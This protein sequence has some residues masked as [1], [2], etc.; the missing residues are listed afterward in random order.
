MGRSRRR[1][2]PVSRKR[3]GGRRGRG[4][5]KTRR[6]S[7]VPGVEDDLAAGIAAQRA[8]DRE[9]ARRRR[10]SSRPS[11][12]GRRAALSVS[13]LAR[14]FAISTGDSVERSARA[15]PGSSRSWTAA[16]APRRGLPRRAAGPGSRSLRQSARARSIRRS[17]SP[18]SAAPRR[19]PAGSRRGRR[20]SPRSRTCGSG[21]RR[22]TS[23]PSRNR[24]CAKARIISHGQRDLCLKLER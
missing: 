5:Q 6:G 9:P 20:R 22:I 1:G 18:S 17:R 4:R 15:G 8:R 19:T 12:P 23:M 3:P 21:P 13:S 11:R 24:R 14:G 7:G 2:E 16:R 10:E